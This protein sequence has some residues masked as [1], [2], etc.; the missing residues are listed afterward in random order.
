MLDNSLIKGESTLIKR[1]IKKLPNNVFSKAYIYTCIFAAI[2]SA[3]ILSLFNG[4]NCKRVVRSVQVRNHTHEH[5]LLI[6]LFTSE[7]ENISRN[8]S[9]NWGCQ[10]LCTPLRSCLSVRYYKVMLCCKIEDMMRK[11]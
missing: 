11:E 5:S 1:L 8:C 4:V 7:I 10:L 2:S 6:Y 9:I 3:I